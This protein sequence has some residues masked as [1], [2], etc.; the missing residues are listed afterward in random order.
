MFLMVEIIDPCTILRVRDWINMWTCEDS[1][2]HT[3]LDYFKFRGSKMK[4]GLLKQLEPSTGAF[5]G[6]DIFEN[7]IKSAYRQAVMKVRPT[8][9]TAC[10]MY[11]LFNDGVI[12][13]NT[14]NHR[15]VICMSCLTTE[16]Y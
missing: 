8:C 5:E 2:V 7:N 16:L 1:S 15:P 10:Y 11:E 3:I 13:R 14:K 9:Q 6:L 12:L 4:K